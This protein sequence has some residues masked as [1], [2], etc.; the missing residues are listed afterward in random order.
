[1]IWETFYHIFNCFREPV[2]RT[3]RRVLSS[4]GVHFGT[5]FIIDLAP[6]SKY[7]II[8]KNTNCPSWRILLIHLCRINPSIRTSWWGHIFPVGARSWL[9]LNAIENLPEIMDFS[10]GHFEA[11]NA[12]IS[13]Q[14]R[15][16]WDPPLIGARGNQAHHP[17]KRPILLH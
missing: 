15:G 11:H 17:P 10:T 4:S 3:S 8:C 14:K 5:L 1:M 16:T 12:F 6:G 9:V 7:V 13:G 2:G